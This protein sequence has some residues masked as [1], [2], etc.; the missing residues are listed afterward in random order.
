[1]SGG[2]TAHAGTVTADFSSFF[3][4][5][6]VVPEE[7]DCYEVVHVLNYYGFPFKT[8]EENF[9][10]HSRKDFGFT[11][12]DDYPFL[13][14]NSSSEEMPEAYIASKDGILTFLFNQ[15]LIGSYKSHSVYEKQG[16]EMIEEKL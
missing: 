11:A 15:G 10:R 8:E 6:V 3:N 4:L 13:V 16:L 2:Q 1:M 12:D 5:L 14:I 9:F 7:P